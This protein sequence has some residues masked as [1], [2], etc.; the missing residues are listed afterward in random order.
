MELIQNKIILNC[1]N[2]KTKD[3]A[4]NWL[5]Q[6]VEKTHYP[7]HL[8]QNWKPNPTVNQTHVDNQPGK[9]RKT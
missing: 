7:N 1:T 9:Y 8:K 2:R 5:K 4:C 3:S 6:I